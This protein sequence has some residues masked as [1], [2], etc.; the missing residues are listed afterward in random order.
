MIFKMLSLLLLKEMIIEFIF[1]YEYMWNHEFFKKCWFYWKKLNII[2]YKNLLTPIKIRKEILIFV[3]I[4]IKKHKFHC[5]K[6]PFFLEDVYADNVLVSNKI[7]SGEKSYRYLFR[8]FYDN[9]KTKPSHIMLP[10]MSA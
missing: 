2:K 7:F 10:K 8:D 1:S 5:Y 6:S 4:K 9:H 3:D